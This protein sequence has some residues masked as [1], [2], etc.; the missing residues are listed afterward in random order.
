MHCS[1]PLSL[2]PN[3]DAQKR[4]QKKEKKKMVLFAS[5]ARMWSRKK[6]ASP[7]SRKSQ[8]EV[9]SFNISCKV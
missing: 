4:S 8:T 3:F 2:V 6:H 9:P 1:D 5:F 7:G